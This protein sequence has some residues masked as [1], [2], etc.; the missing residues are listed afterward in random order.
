[1]KFVISLAFSHPDHI[2]EL[3]RAAEESGFDAIAVSDHVVHPEKIESAYPYTEDGSPRWEAPAPW[4]DP[5]VTIGAMA[6]T[7]S[8]LRFFTNIFVLPMRNPFSVAKAVGT[9][10]ILS[11]GRVALGIG[12][13]WMKDEFRLLEQDFYTRGRRTDEM[14]EV[15]QTL[16][17]GG[18]VEHHGEFYDFDRLQMSPAPTDPIP[19]YFGGLSERALERV[20]RIGDGWISDIHRSDEIRELIARIR[21][22]RE[23]AGRRDAP[24]DVIASVSDV[25]D[26]EGYRRLEDAGVTHINTMPWVFYKGATDSLEEKLAGLR[27]F[28]DEIIEPLR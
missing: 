2:L 26:A 3:A 21:H 7:T 17:R 11:R 14:I 10:Q 5:W 12:V 23:A 18:M 1:V 28:A 20:G 9:A 13:G 24:L 8:R 22:H 15:M 19:L 4:P 27:Q 6:A 25:A 16:W